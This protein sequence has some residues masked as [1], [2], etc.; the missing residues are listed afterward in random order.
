M[1]VRGHAL[2]YT[3]NQW[4]YIWCDQY[5]FG[6]CICVCSVVK[7]PIDYCKNKEDKRLQF[8]TTL[9][10]PYLITLLMRS[11]QV[12]TINVV[13]RL[14][15]PTKV[16]DMALIKDIS[17]LTTLATGFEI[18]NI[19]GGAPSSDLLVSD[20]GISSTFTP[21]VSIHSQPLVSAGQTLISISQLEE[22]M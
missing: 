3:H 19:I 13:H 10:S 6:S 11:A 12:L 17:N 4:K 7:H 20:D 2:D 8:S 9:P 1:V 15:Q 21:L 14:I 22:I 5:F 16:A 18:P